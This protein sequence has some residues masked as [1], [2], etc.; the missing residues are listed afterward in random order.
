MVEVVVGEVLVVV[1]VVVVGEVVVLVVEE[2]VVEGCCGLVS[3]P[4]L[5]WSSPSSCMLASTTTAKAS[6]ISHRATSLGAIPTWCR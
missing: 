5:S 1:L 3:V 4:Y 2:E 6:F